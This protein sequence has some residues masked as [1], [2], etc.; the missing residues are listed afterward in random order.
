[1]GQTELRLGQ[2]SLQEGQ[3]VLQTGQVKIQDELV[4]I[5]EVM[6]GK[7]SGN[8]PQSLPSTVMPSSPRIFGRQSYINKVVQFLLSAISTHLV[9]LGPGGIGKTSVA[10]ST[11]H[12]SCV[13]ERFGIYRRWVPCEQAT[14]LPLFF[15][16]IAKSLGLP[17]STTNDRFSEIV[18]ALEESG[19]LQFV[20]FD[21]FETIWDLEG[22]Q[23]AIANILARLAS[24]PSLSFILTMRGIQ[25]PASNLIDWTSPRLPPLTPLEMDPAQEAFLKIS[26]DSEG[27]DNLP[28]LLRELDCMPLA[29]TLMAKLAEVGET[30]AELLSQWKQEQVKLLSQPGGDRTSSIEVSI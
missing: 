29:I 12:D 6:K 15:E 2:V 21:N 16:L 8:A 25:H 19:V 18:A 7:I 30:V 4:E 26:P 24:I 17:P 5:R 28:E 9:I 3:T 14:S 10:L 1:M 27:D 13:I 23:S 11:V 22:E 20:L